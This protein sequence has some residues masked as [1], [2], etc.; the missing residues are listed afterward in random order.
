MNSTM[1]KINIMNLKFSKGTPYLAMMAM[2]AMMINED[3]YMMLM[4]SPYF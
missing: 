4:M 3:R 1:T 2:M